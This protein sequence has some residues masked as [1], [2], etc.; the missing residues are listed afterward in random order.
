MVAKRFRN[1]EVAG[2]NLAAALRVLTF[3]QPIV[4]GIP[5]GGMVVAARVAS[6]LNAELGTVVSKKLLSPYQPELALGAVTSDGFAY[7]DTALAEEVGASPQYLREE[8]RRQAEQAR[9][10]QELL[11]GSK[12]YSIEGRDVLVIDDGSATGA[13]AIAVVRQAWASGATQVIV[14]VPVA[15]PDALKRLRNEATE[16]VCL[17][18]AP[19][20]V[21]VS[22]CYEHFRSID[23]QV[24]RNFLIHHL[25]A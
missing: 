13:S 22:Q 19:G 4:L 7:V 12:K 20:F 6:E 8:E 14:A 2:S 3:N 16:V 15:P 11:D 25:P 10:H 17:L 9:Q 21:S 18:E 5:R 23:D 1:R 24:V